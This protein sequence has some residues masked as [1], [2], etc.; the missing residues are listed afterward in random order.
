MAHHLII[1]NEVDELLSK[2]AIEPLTGGAGF[3]STIFVVP[4]HTGAF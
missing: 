1:H 2:G 4:K 3:Y